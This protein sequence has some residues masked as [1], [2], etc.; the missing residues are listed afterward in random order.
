[1]KLDLALFVL[2][3]LLCALTAFALT[4][5]EPPGGHGAPHPEYSSMLHGGDGAARHGPVLWLGWGIGVLEILFFVACMALGARKGDSLRGLGLPLVAAAAVYIAVWTCLIVS[6][7]SYMTVPDPTLYLALPAPTAWMLYVMWPI[8]LI[9]V[10]LFVFG[11]R[12]WVL[13]E[14]DEVKFR[15]IVA[16][17]TARTSRVGERG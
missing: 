15:R 10:C 13:S 4:I 5:P 2:I 14:E 16:L 7:Q 1:M 6:Y 8:P 17:R 12:R 3:V 11:F 9:F